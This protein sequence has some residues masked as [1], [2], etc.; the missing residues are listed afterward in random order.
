MYHASLAGMRFEREASEVLN[1]RRLIV[2]GALAL[3]TSAVV[4]A[5][6]GSLARF[7]SRV[8]LVEVYATV[9]DERGE[10]VTGLS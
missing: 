3:A 7:S 2:A 1:M 4:L 8:Q 5:Q 9:T 10:L 6:E